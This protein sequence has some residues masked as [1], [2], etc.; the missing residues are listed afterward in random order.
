MAPY[1]VFVIT[2]K[3]KTV[4]FVRMMTVWVFAVFFRMQKVDEHFNEYI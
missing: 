2:I 4:Y 3:F 1:L